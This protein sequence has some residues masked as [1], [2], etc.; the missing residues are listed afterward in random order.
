MRRAPGPSHEIMRTTRVGEPSHV[1]VRQ[2]QAGRLGRRAFP[3]DEQ[4]LAFVLAASREDP[5]GLPR[6]NNSNMS[7]P[8]R[9]AEQLGPT[10]LWP[11]DASPPDRS[12]NPTTRPAATMPKCPMDQDSRPL[13]HQSEHLGRRSRRT[14]WQPAGGDTKGHNRGERATTPDG[15]LGPPGARARRAGCQATAAPCKKAYARKMRT[16]TTARETCGRPSSARPGQSVAGCVRAIFVARG[17]SSRRK[18]PLAAWRRGWQ[19]P[20][21]AAR[22]LGPQPS[23]CT[24][25]PALY[26]KRG[27]TMPAVGPGPAPPRLTTGDRRAPCRIARGGL[28]LMGR[29]LARRAGP[30]RAPT[31]RALFRAGMRNRVVSPRGDWTGD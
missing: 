8:A 21:R 7:P 27:G 24:P 14:T 31:N 28:G 12:K 1:E 17:G 26:D 11:P 23:G 29:H 30:P 22:P 10:W 16:C 15:P 18:C 20:L 9:G 5:Q 3:K 4:E 25:Q 6:T 2:P 13:C 19:P